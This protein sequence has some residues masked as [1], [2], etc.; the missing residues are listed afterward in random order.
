[1]FD[2]WNIFREITL[3]GISLDLT[4]DI[5]ISSGNDLVSSGKKPLPEPNLT[6]TY[7]I[8]RPQVVNQIVTTVELEIFLPLIYIYIYIYIVHTTIQSWMSASR[9][10]T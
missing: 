6:Q 7:G 1:M 8:A 4:N 2:G 3:K 9:N 10:S 5:C